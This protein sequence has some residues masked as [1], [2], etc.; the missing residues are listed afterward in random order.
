M[1]GLTSLEAVKRKIKLLQ[2]QADSAEEKAEKL[3]KDLAVERKAR[4]AVSV[5]GAGRKIKQRV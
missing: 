5:C 3:Q 4:E 1:A 2:E